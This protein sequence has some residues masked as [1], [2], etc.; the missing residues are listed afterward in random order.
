M[1]E[2]LTEHTSPE[3]LF[4]ETEWASLVSYGITADLLKLVPLEVVEK[5]V[6]SLE[7][8]LLLMAEEMVHN[9]LDL[10]AA[11]MVKAGGKADLEDLAFSS[12]L[13]LLDK[14]PIGCY[15]PKY[16]KQLRF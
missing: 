10:E 14:Y 16:L 6:F 2:L 5:V 15:N 1:A 9:P 3:L 12:S 8:L 4:L 7:I 13:I 11:V